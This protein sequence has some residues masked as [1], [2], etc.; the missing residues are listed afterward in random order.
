MRK[1]LT[2][3]MTVLFVPLLAAVLLLFLR[4]SFTQTLQRELQRAQMA[5]GI[6][7]LQVRDVFDGITYAQGVEAARDYRNL[8]AT[9]GLELLCIYSGQPVA[10]AVLPGNAAQVLL[11]GSRAALLDTLTAPQ[12]YLI[13]DP[14]SAQW[15][16]LTLRDVSDL[17]SLRDALRRTAL[18]IVLAG[19]LLMALLAYGLATWFT[20][21]IKRLTGAVHAMRQSAFNPAQLPR[22]AQDEV[23]TLS[24]AFIAMH[25]AVAERE[26]HLQQESKARQRLLDALA[27]EMRTPLCALLGNTRL[28]Q[29]PAVPEA[30]R[31]RLANEMVGDIK[32]LTDMDT[33]LLKLTALAHEPLSVAPVAVLPL[34]CDSARR[35]GHQAQGVTLVAEG[36]ESMISG[37]AELLSLMVDNLALN[38]VHASQNGGTV[39][40][41]SLTNGFTVK[42]TGIGMTAEQLAHAQEPFYKAD[43][44]RTRKAGGV[45]LGL[46]LCRQIAQLHCG[47]LAISATPGQGTTVT[48]TTSLQPDA[49]LAT[50]Q[51]VS[52]PQ[53]VKPT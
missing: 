36:V 24:Q 13:A 44:A 47:T 16:L 49:D 10:G 38:A 32:R 11:V 30:A 3:W 53:E 19:G 26:A 43:P 40:L 34:L 27:H 33:Q 39:T 51:G 22:P 2:L 37:D 18:W 21:P 35:I 15:T 28:M 48:F 14:L 20:A 45:G 5:E 25:A 9:Q 29:N 52:L 23:G 12:R 8:Y 6:I 50:R 17:Y 42:D 46:T 41:T 1:R 7:Y 31:H 4:Q